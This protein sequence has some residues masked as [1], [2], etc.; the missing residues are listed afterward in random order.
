MT[1][2]GLVV[3][4]LRARLMGTRDVPPILNWSTSSPGWTVGTHPPIASL[5]GALHALSALQTKWHPVAIAS[6]AWRTPAIDDAYFN[7]DPA[8]LQT[9][10]TFWS[11]E[12]HSGVASRAPG[13][14]PF[15][16]AR[17]KSRP[18]GVADFSHQGQSALPP[19]SSP[20]W[21]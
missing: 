18:Y 3:V 1:V 20:Q 21:F 16:R 7:A 4:M 19:G 17:N 8:S 9:K 5:V 2:T 10:T 12:S 14:T 6:R 11:L 13:R 15:G